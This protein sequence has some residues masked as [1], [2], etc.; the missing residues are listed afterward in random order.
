MINL[1]LKKKSC[2][3]RNCLTECPSGIVNLIKNIQLY[4]NKLM[5]FW[6]SVLEWYT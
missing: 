2:G 5:A 6:C 1:Q 4:K 3:Y